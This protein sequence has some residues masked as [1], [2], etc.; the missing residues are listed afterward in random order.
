[1][2]ARP[3]GG[4]AGTWRFGPVSGTRPFDLTIAAGPYVEEWQGEG[5][6]AGPVR[7]GIWRRRSLDGA[8]WSVPRRWG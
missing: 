1:V 3:P 8:A 6:T 5:G 7:M 4:A 2:T